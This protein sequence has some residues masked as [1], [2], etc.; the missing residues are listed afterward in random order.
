M[1]RDA[2]IGAQRGEVVVCVELGGPLDREHERLRRCLRSVVEH[3]D[4]RMAIV[5]VGDPGAPE[6][7]PG[8]SGRP[9][10]TC[11]DLARAFA[12]AAPAD[13]VVLSSG[14]V[15][16]GGW[17]EG[18]RDAALTDSRV[19]TATALCTDD[20][21]LSPAAGEPS[22]FDQAAAKL[23]AASP[24]LRPRLA[25]PGRRCAYVRRTALELV[26]EVSDLQEISVR[27]V[28]IGLSHVLADEVLV[29]C[30]GAPAEARPLAGPGERDS[31]AP[32]ARSL[33]AAR[34]ALHG[35]SVMIDARILA[36]P[37][38]GTKLH[39]LELVAAVA[40]AHTDTV[41]ALIGGDLDRHT[42]ALLEQAPGLKL[43]PLPPT[44]GLRAGVRADLV[45]RP[46]QVDSPADLVVLGQLGERLVV[47]QQDVISYQ[48]ASYFRSVQAWE[49]YRALTR[50][51]L[52]AADRVLFFSEHA[53]DEALAEDL[54]ARDRSSVVHIGV[55][56]A[57]ARKGREEPAAPAGAERLSDK[58]GVM[59]CIGSDY[60]H[61]NRVFAL[62]LLE[63]LQRAHNWRGSLVLAGRHL[64]FGSSREAE[65]HLLGAQPALREAV[66]DMGEVSEAEKEWLLR[67]ASV[68]V[69]P[70]VYEGFGLV[71]FEAAEYGVPCLW[72]QGTS[73][74]EILPDA[75]AGIVPWDVAASAP[76]ALA[77]MGDEAA[78]ADNLSA[79]RTAAASLRWEAAAAGLIEAYGA[80]CDEPPAP[81][82]AFERSEGLMQPGLS[83][84]AVR[85][86]GPDGALPRELERPLLALAAHPK[87]RG[88]VFGALKA[89]YRASHRLRR[90]PA[91]SSE[92]EDR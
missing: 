74:S 47:T 52:T 9:M 63:E 50:T 84:D 30:D 76:R 28:E 1:E 36:G 79:I 21:P 29:R 41:T 10:R 27:A 25:A 82:G 7:G 64:P 45:H 83:E 92:P 80:T 57:L 19:A 87:L 70:T 24:R 72:A 61:K 33:G 67:R 55:D 34:R 5:V 71:P 11:A 44:P 90:G 68:V 15:V 73:L 23:L 49:G 65:E 17:L 16:A 91:R 4:E 18:L 62:R 46:Y 35:V 81:A 54:V 56:H 86:V 20:G 32:L 12:A 69:Y 42:R 6:L 66:L 38:D 59:L 48:T 31:S 8:L 39:V 14:C 37:M 40:R 22:S 2:T 43:M 53:R 89:G 3:T 85:L 13:V 58:E 75:A 78:R 60:R 77:L 26:G 51:A 88:P